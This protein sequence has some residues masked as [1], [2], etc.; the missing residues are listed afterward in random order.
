L[1][2]VFAFALLGGMLVPS[3]RADQDNNAILFS[4]SGPVE[5][6]G[7]LLEPGKY[8]LRLMG[9]G[10]TIAEVW[11][12]DGSRFY[13]F[14]DTMPAARTHAV[15]RAR[16]VVAASNTASP[17]RIEAWFYP[18]HRQGNQ[19]LYPDAQDVRPA[20]RVLPHQSE[21]NR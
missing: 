15:S 3:A 6:P 19:L 4:V 13:G 7:R 14:F 9:D 11:K 20:S 5:I 8:E 18:G 12:A 10:S 1:A 17:K 2:V 21:V 16:V